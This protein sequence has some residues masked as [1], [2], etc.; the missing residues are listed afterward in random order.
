[1]A[2][3]PGKIAVKDIIKSLLESEIPDIRDVARELAERIKQL[4]EHSWKLE[5]YVTEIESLAE[6]A[7]VGAPE[8]NLG[9]LIK[10]LEKTLD[11]L[12]QKP[13]GAVPKVKAREKVIEEVEEEAEEEVEE[14]AGGIA[15]EDVVE[16]QR[17]GVGVETYLT[18]EGFVVKKHR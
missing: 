4:E 13:A 2:R 8:A 15:R 12:R 5:H 11:E 16:G 10:D 17:L 1:M 9:E 3:K 18:P 6:E 14:K 7:E